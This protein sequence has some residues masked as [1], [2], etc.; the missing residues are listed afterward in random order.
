MPMSESYTLTLNS[1]T[2]KLGKDTTKK[3]TNFD[4]GDY[5]KDY[6][7]WWGYYKIDYKFR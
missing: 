1:D 6:K 5:K 7:L 3:T 2:T 4:N